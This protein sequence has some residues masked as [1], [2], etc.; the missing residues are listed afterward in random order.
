MTSTLKRYYKWG[1]G[2]CCYGDCM[3]LHV[4]LF[5]HSSQ[6]EIFVTNSPMFP[7]TPLIHYRIFVSLLSLIHVEIS[8]TFY[9]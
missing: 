6:I 1:L 4:K 3:R 5:A 2:E 8:S 9:T 7:S